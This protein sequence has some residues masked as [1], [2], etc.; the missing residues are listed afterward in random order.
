MGAKIW[1]VVHMNMSM[2]GP[3][4][5]AVFVRGGLVRPY[6]GFTSVTAM[7][8]PVDAKFVANESCGIIRF[9]VS[10]LIFETQVR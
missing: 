8:N 7:E 6:E 4:Q 5:T 2:D 9:T 3:P 1:S 10:F